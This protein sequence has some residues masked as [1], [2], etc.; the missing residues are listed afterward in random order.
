MRT[1]HMKKLLSVLM[2]AGLAL[3]AATLWAQ[4]AAD[5]A[6]Q[7]A[8]VASAPQLSYGADQILRLAQAKVGDGTIIAFIKNSGNSY[9]LDA[10][11]I[12]YLRQQGLS[13]TVISAMLNHPNSVLAAAST[14]TT[15]SASTITTPSG[16]TATVAPTVTYVQSAPASGVYVIPDTQTYYYD[17]A[18]YQPYYYPYYGWSYPAVSLSF[19]FGGYHGG[20]YHSGGFHGGGYHAGGGF[21]GGFH[22]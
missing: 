19:G 10:G 4:S 17:S 21:H 18:Y 15:A 12:I 13:D 1:N 11:Q 20:G 3:P 2:V 8:S 7:S 5:T 22:R 14:V 6:A 9:P 16:S